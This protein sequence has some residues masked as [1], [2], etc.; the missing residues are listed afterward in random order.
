MSEVC[1]TVTLSVLSTITIL[2]DCQVILPVLVTK[3]VG[4]YEDEQFCI[5]LYATFKLAAE[6]V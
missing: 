6:V 3:K 4:A 5:E 2:M 1:V